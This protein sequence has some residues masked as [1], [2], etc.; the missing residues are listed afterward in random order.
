MNLQATLQAQQNQRQSKSSVARA[1]MLSCGRRQHSESVRA[2]FSGLAVRSILDCLEVAPDW[3]K[4]VGE[5]EGFA[6]G[7]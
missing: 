2:S 1:Q 5:T 7:C 6:S 4:L 3:R